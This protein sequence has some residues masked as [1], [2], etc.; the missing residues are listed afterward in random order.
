VTCLLTPVWHALA[1]GCGQ[2]W[3]LHSYPVACMG[4]RYELHEGMYMVDVI[5]HAMH[6]P[7]TFRAGAYVLSVTLGD[8]CGPRM[9]CSRLSSPVACDMH[10]CALWTT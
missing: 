9:V 2:P 6:V 10:A 5:P 8:V 3:W 1:V 4:M 7:P